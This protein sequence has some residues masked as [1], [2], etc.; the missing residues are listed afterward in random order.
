MY[1]LWLK[2]N[3]DKSYAGCNSLVVIW[4]FLKIFS[5]LHRTITSHGQDD[6][7]Y[8]QVYMIVQD[9]KPPGIPLQPLVYFNIVPSI[10]A[11]DKRKPIN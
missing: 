2:A 9:L 10:L 4:V 1:T 3:V 5:R 11:V 8:G 6:T 7:V